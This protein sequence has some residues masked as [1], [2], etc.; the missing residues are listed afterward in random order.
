MR[1]GRVLQMKIMRGHKL[2]TW[3]EEVKVRVDVVHKIP[4]DAYTYEPLITNDDVDQVDSIRLRTS[5]YIYGI[6]P[7]T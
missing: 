1:L 5:T 2:I 3:R 6:G 7:Y 4:Q